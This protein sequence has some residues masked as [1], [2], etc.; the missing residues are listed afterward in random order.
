MIK[1]ILLLAV[2]FNINVSVTN[3]GALVETENVG[4]YI[5]F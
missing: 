5:E 1:I 2:L 3:S 4:Y